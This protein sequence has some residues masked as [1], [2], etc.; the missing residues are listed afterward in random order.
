MTSLEQIKDDFINLRIKPTGWLGDSPTRFDRYTYY[1]KQVNSIIEF[2]VYTGL[3]TT[4][5]LLGNPK[6]LVSYDTFEDNFFIKKDLEM[7][8]LEHSINFEFRIGH[9]HYIKPEFTDLL[10]IDTEHTYDHVS[11]ELEIH[12]PFVNKF[13]LLH[14]VA[15]CPEVLYAAV[16]YIV[17]N[18]EWVIHEHCNRG[19]GLLVLKKSQRE[20]IVKQESEVWFNGDY[21]I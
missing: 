2:G 9:T 4:A 15:A 7:Y 8:A 3:S 5:F 21:N 1:A 18:P 6:R 16:D 19:S 13:I 12:A 14:D 17:K 20:T 10:F 11:K